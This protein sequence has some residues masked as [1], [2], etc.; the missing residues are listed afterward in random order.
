MV[1]PGGTRTWGD[2]E[3]ICITYFR[4]KFPFSIKMND[5]VQVVL[6]MKKTV[7]LEMGLYQLVVSRIWLDLA[8]CVLTVQAK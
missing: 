2:I 7:N 3:K 6:K 8:W 4:C 1:F 5:C